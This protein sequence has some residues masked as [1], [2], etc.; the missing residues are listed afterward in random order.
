[1]PSSHRKILPLF[2]LTG[3]IGEAN[4]QRKLDHRPDTLKGKS[5]EKYQGASSQGVTNQG[6]AKSERYRGQ[7]VGKE[8]S[9]LLKIKKGGH[10]FHLGDTSGD[11]Q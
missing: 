1:V 3:E 8:K 6:S 5:Q 11:D 4:T 2:K 9:A 7:K 10:L